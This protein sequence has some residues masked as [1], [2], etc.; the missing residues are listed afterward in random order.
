MKGIPAIGDT[1][2]NWLTYLKNR[3]QVSSISA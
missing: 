1:F 3:W 2:A